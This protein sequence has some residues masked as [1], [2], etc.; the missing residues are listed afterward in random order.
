MHKKV[1]VILLNEYMNFRAMEKLE[2]MCSIQFLVTYILSEILLCTLLY[3][4]Q[5]VSS[6]LFDLFNLQ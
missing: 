3:T 6:L 4:I 2:E 1:P 5:M